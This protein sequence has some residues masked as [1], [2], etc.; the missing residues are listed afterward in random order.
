MGQERNKMI[1]IDKPGLTVWTIGSCCDEEMRTVAIYQLR[2]AGKSIML[3]IESYGSG[4]RLEIDIPNTRHMSIAQK[5][6]YLER[7]GIQKESIYAG[8]GEYKW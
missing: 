4:M 3:V 6:G 7:I 5:V 8:Q 1:L 2:A